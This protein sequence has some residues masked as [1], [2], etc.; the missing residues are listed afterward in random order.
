MGESSGV[1]INRRGPM[2]GIQVLGCGLID[3]G[4]LSVAG[5]GGNARGPDQGP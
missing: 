5:K 1:Q 4:V 3:G 2:D